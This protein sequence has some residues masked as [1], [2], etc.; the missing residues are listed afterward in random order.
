MYIYLL[1]VESPSK[2]KLIESFLGKEYKVIATHGHLCSLEGLKS[3][4]TKN[5]FESN[6]TIIKDK[7]THINYMRSII[8]SYPK[9][10]IFLATDNDNEGEKIAYDICFIFNLDIAITKR[11]FFSSITSKALNYAILN[12]TLID[13]NIIRIQKCRQI[14]DILIGFK[15]SP[16][17]WKHI[18]KG[19]SSLSAG[20]CQSVGLKLIYENYIESKSN[21]TERKYKTVANFFSYPCTTKFNLNCDFKYADETKNFLEISK[22][23][24][25]NLLL[26]KKTIVV[27]PPPLP[28]NT[29]SLLLNSNLP[30]NVTMKLAQQLYQEGYITYIRTDSI[31]YSSEFIYIIEKFL[32]TKYNDRKIINSFDGIKNIDCNICSHEAIRVVDLT[33]INIKGDSKLKKLYDIIYNNTVQSCMSD[34]KYNS[35]NTIISA[36]LCHQYETVLQTPLYLGWQT[37]HGSKIDDSHILNFIESRTDKIV[38]YQFIESQISISNTH[39]YYTENNMISKMIHLKIGRP[40]TYVNFSEINLDRKYIKIGDVKG[41]EIDCLDFKL[42]NDY[43]IFETITKKIFN[44]EKNKLLIQPIGIQCIEFLIKYF[45]EIFENDYSKNLDLEL[46]RIENDSSFVNICKKTNSLI[47]KLKKQISSEY[48]IDKDFVLLFQKFGPIIK[49]CSTNEYIP[50]KKNI[51]I[52]MEKLIQNEYH[53]DELTLYKQSFL[54]CYLEKNVSIN[55][56]EFGPF[57]KWNDKNYTLR[58][59]DIN[60]HQITI[61]KAIEVIETEKKP[62]L[63]RKNNLVRYINEE[64]SVRNGKFG[65]YIYYQSKFMK[66]PKFFTVGPDIDALSCNKDILVSIYSGK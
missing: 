25:H 2:I 60:L 11:I 23:F 4:D 62:E 14:I 13:M 33:L 28:F 63:E 22:T 64:S 50:L 55:D 43:N 46:D 12:P 9:E 42:D 59:F 31:K 5:N 44:K 29:A 56:G 53:I 61:E 8:E 47:N 27:K 34:A 38:N 35:Y 20:R 18:D 32:I 21:I 16:L 52:N 65:L 36:P 6:Y 49:N 51:Q 17:L 26:G 24:D 7:I 40:S 15:I 37:Y 41:I 57:L 48:V 3:I 10:N 30:P 1:I 45:N 19:K 39:S 66:K 58:D 54:G